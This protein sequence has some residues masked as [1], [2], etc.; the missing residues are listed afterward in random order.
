MDGIS[1]EP[2][3]GVAFAGLLKLISQQIIQP[4]DI[5][6]I[7]CS[8]HTIPVE[9]ELLG[10]AWARSVEA[11][12][13]IPSPK[14]IIQREGLVAAL[15][16]LDERVKS[17]AIVDDNPNAVR[18]LKRILQA[19]GKYI[20]HEAYGGRE[21]L[22]IIRSERPDMVLL[23]LTMPEMDGFAVLEAMKSDERLQNIPVIVISALS[24]QELAPSKRRQLAD[25]VKVMLQKGAYTDLDLLEN[26][27]EEVL[28]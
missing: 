27:I 26:I 9:A 20:I 28:D 12:E 22:S 16:R 7:N 21:G 5:V 25:Q 4:K 10:E 3:A 24:S 14:P 2:A 8:G 15:E 1:M 13:A 17:I 23:D 19:R 18:L 11:P 6:A